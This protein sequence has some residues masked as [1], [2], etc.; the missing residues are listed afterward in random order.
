[1]SE[2]LA[3]TG[4]VL[5]GG[6]SRRF[7]GL[8]KGRLTVGGR[9]LL[10][11]SLD[12]LTSVTSAQ[13]LVGGRASDGVTTLPDQYPGEGPLGG[14]LTAL[15][16]VPTSHALVVACDLPF[17][18]PEFLRLVQAAGETQPMA[19]VEAAD[20]QSPL[21]LSLRHDTRTA[22]ATYWKAGGRRINGLR[23]VLA[24]AT[25]CRTAIARLDPTGRVLLNVNDPLTYARALEEAR[26]DWA[27]SYFTDQ[28]ESKRTS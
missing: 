21:C 23:G 6:R 19:C 1:M 13:F 16:H 26:H 5:A 12:A 27:A 17:L 28:D 2:R 4:I 14:L 9:T 15:G 7:G 3:W 22:I 11:R 24:H 25:V 20:G 10:Q 8:D 18:T